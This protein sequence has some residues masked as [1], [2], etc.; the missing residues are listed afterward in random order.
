[1]VEN[2]I[3]IPDSIYSN[4]VGRKAREL[5][6]STGMPLGSLAKKL[7]CSIE[8]VQ[9]AFNGS[10]FAGRVVT[11]IC[12]KN[13]FYNQ[14]KKVSELNFEKRKKELDATHEFIKNNIA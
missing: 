6:R 4:D 10:L 1:M 8:L 12:S 7:K 9:S 5:I 14:V 11:L 3:V 2:E 13:G